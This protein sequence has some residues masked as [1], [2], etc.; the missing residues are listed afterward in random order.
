VRGL[1][2][3]CPLRNRKIQHRIDLFGGAAI[4]GQRDPAKGL[5]ARVFRKRDVLRELMPRKKPDCRAA[6]LEERD[7]LAGCAKFSRKTQRLV[8]R[9]TGAH[10]ADAERDHGEARNRRR[11]FLIHAGTSLQY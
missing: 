8:K 10:V 1:Q 9:D 4:P 5:R 11:R 6:G 3:Q 7:G 2:Q